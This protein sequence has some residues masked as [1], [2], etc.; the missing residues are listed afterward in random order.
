MLVQNRIF[1]AEAPRTQRKHFSFGGRYRQTRRFP[2]FQCKLRNRRH[3]HQEAS[4][5]FPKACLPAGRDGVFDPIAVSRLRGRSRY[6][7][8]KARLDQK[9]T[10]LS[11][12]C[13]SAV[14]LILKG[15]HAN[16]RA[17]WNQ[18]KSQSILDFLDSSDL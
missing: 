9:K 7:A 18:P 10:P 8:A 14:S 4:V 3:R 12:L 2:S 15:A 6:G 16:Q 5:F 11:D 17:Q 1:T 13:G